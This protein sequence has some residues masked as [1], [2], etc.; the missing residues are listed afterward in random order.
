MPLT[1]K[2]GV[3]VVCHRNTLQQGS[4]KGVRMF[5]YPEG[6]EKYCHRKD[7]VVPGLPNCPLRHAQ[8]P[9]YRDHKAL[10]KGT[11]GGGL[12]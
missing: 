11:R 9:S 1:P 2:E 6:S 4:S 8:I 5:Q 3:T 12:G 7:M 10:N